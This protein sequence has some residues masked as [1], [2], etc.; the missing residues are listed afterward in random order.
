[1]KRFYIETV[2]KDSKIQEPGR[3]RRLQICKA[4]VDVFA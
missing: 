4:V 2:E 3:Y 1:M